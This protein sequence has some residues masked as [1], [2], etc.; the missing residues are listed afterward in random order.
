M[1]CEPHKNPLQRSGT[2]QADRR[3][4]GLSPDHVRIDERRYSDWI[5]FAAE[6]SKWLRF[7]DGNTGAS[8]QGWQAFFARDVSAV[9]GGFAVQDIETWRLGLRERL[10]YLRDD[11]HAADE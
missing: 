6:F 10:D 3:L 9:L 5:V 7:Y 4:P 8:L 1:A 11:G 2:S